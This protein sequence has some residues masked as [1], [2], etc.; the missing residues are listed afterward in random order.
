MDFR[1]GSLKTTTSVFG[2][3]LLLL[4]CS[5]PYAQAEA[6]PTVLGSRAELANS[7]LGDPSTCDPT[8]PPGTPLVLAE[9]QVWHGSDSHASAYSPTRCTSCPCD[10]GVPCFSVPPPYDSTDLSTAARQIQDAKALGIDGFVIDWYGPSDPKLANNAGRLFMDTAT[11]ALFAAADDPK[12]GGFCLALMYDEGT[13]RDSDLPPGEKYQTQA[14]VD[15]T[16]ADTTYLSSP[17]YLRLDGKPALFVFAYDQVHIHLRYPDLRA[18]ALGPVVLL[19]RD[20]NPLDPTH[21]AAFDGFYAWVW[22]GAAGWDSKGAAWGEPYLQWFYSTMA[23]TDYAGKIALGGVWP[24]F[25]DSLAPWCLHRYMART[26]GAVYQATWD[27]ATASGVEIVMI[28]TWNDFEEGTDIEYG[29]DMVVDMD[30]GLPPSLL[31]S[32]PVE[33]TWTPGAGDVFQIYQNCALICEGSP[34][35]PLT[36]GV[37]PGIAYELK[38]W[39][40][41]QPQTVVIKARRPPPIFCDGFELG[42]T[43]AWLAPGTFECPPGTKAVRSTGGSDENGLT[44]NHSRWLST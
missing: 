33:V 1:I 13:L 35:P 38:L 21:D 39:Q 32:S 12:S 20:P 44:P 6:K 18:E 10:P 2:I 31:R 24:G 36:L 27:L 26:G 28:A 8:T 17:V 7:A 37:L 22:P 30:P 34:T 23:T 19:D 11:Q 3:F 41:P 5:G 9:I 25:D 29:I 15:L 16:Y 4:Y 40:G 14:K 42:D 43:S